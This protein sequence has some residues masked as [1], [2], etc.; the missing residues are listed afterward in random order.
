M[1]SA[2]SVFHC[3]GSGF[4]LPGSIPDFSQSTALLTWRFKC[5]APGALRAIAACFVSGG[6]IG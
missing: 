5:F 2:A 4:H 6:L 3:V 1:R